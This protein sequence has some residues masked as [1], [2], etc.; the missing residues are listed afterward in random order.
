VEHPSARR[1]TS[2]DSRQL[3]ELLT[4]LEQALVA[5]TEALRARDVDELGRA[6]ESKRSA[7]ALLARMERK[8]VGSLDDE[9]AKLL[10]RCRV[11]NDIAG[12][13]IAVLR[14]DTNHA[15]ALLGIDSETPGYGSPGS[16]RRKGRALAAC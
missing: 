10:A 6:V 1:D 7:L 2:A 13:A 4:A 16:P 5:E 9:I 14:Q 12:S 15:L 3:R 11:L 8:D